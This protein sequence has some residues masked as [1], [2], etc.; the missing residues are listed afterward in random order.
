MKKLLLLPIFILWAVF[1]YSQNI[2]P[3]PSGNVGIGTVSP[4][5]KLDVLGSSRIKDGFLNSDNYFE[6]VFP[7]VAFT[8]GVANLAV[9]LKLG[10]VQ[11]WGY[12]EVEI[13]STYNYQNSVGKLTKTYAVG[14][15]TGGTIYTNE[16]RVSD[17]VGTIGDNISLGELSWDNIN[18]T[19]KIPISHIVST[20]NNYT[21]KVKMF[22]NGTWAKGV[23]DVITIGSSYTLASLPKN[24]VYFNGNVGIGTTNPTEKLEVNG[25]LQLSGTIR[26]GNSGVRTESRNNAGLQGNAGAMSGFYETYAPLNFPKDDNN[27]WHLI[28]VRHSNPN[29]NYAMQFSG[30]FF[31]QKMYF[32]KTNANVA[33]SWR[34][35]VAMDVN[36]RINLD[37]DVAAL[38]KSVV[39]GGYVYG[40]AI[41]F[42]SNSA[43]A[44][45]RNLE[46]GNLD[47]NGIFYPSIVVSSETG[48]VGIG[49]QTPTGKFEIIAPG[50]GKQSIVIASSQNKAT[51]YTYDTDRT[52]SFAIN[53]NSSSSNTRLFA[54]HS[55]GA[56]QGSA[57]NGSIFEVY[58]HNGTSNIPTISANNNGNVGIGTSVPVSPL[59]IVGGVNSGIRLSGNTARFTLTDNVSNLW[60]MDNVGGTL[61]IFRE[62]YS[63]TS[64]G[65]NGSV[66]MAIQN[67]GNVTIGTTLTPSNYKLAVGGDVIAERVVVKL[68]TAWPDFVFKKNYGLRP[69][70][71]VEAFINQN[72]H[73]PEVPS[74]AEVAD[75]G[76]DVGA[77]NSKLLQKVE[78]LTLYLIEIKK[79]NEAIKARL[80]RV[81]ANK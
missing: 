1:G 36:G 71:E 12:L 3:T 10:N 77:M 21:V 18:S 29:N 76:I 19:Y 50:D 74:A 13:T 70:S 68:Q 57:F 51:F 56:T 24:Y 15:V 72:S 61:R 28:D 53:G 31:D 46:L 22:S 44:N 58:G 11:L 64:N 78:E 20:G 9:D 34:E 7:D 25:N 38:K 5:Y 75:K 6:K 37:N 47:N 40:G 43:V 16:S 80:Q 26:Y 73:L 35:I 42:N 81:E 65:G 67:N 63:A 14:T 8:N 4:I 54:I 52:T 32:R 49:T 55:A 30:S 59:H 27:W 41:R 69:L 2:F 79:E 60:N 66:S 17:V 45:N 33:Q 62:D 48:N 39:L 23:F